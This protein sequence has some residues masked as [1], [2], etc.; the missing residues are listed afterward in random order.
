MNDA[1]GTVTFTPEPGFSGP[2]QGNYRITDTDGHTSDAVM[3]VVV[4]TPPTA[5]A[6]HR[7]G[8]PGT[9]T[10]VDVLGNDGP[11]TAPIDPASVRLVDPKTGKLVDTVTIAGE[12]TFTVQPSG[13]VT[14]TPV[15]GYAGTATI[16]YSVAGEDGSRATAAVSVTIPVV[17]GITQNRRRAAASSSPP[18]AATAWRSPAATCCGP[19]SVPR[20]S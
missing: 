2:T 16:R 6:D 13:T 8:K 9:A 18:R 1:D 15:D 10:V 7:D 11:G 14:F 12:G 4:G 19:A 3:T 20:S 5:K 17:P